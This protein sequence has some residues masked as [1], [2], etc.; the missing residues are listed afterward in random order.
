MGAPLRSW[1]LR[2][3]NSLA[4]WHSTAAQQQPALL[5]NTSRAG[6]LAT[7]HPFL[8]PPLRNAAGT[9]PRTCRPPPASAG[10]TRQA[11]SPPLP[12]PRPAPPFFARTAATTT[13]EL[14]PAPPPPQPYL[15]RARRET[16]GSGSRRVVRCGVVLPTHDV[17]AGRELRQVGLGTGEAR[18]LELRLGGRRRKLLRRRRAVRTDLAGGGG[19]GCGEAVK[20]SCRTRPAPP[21]RAAAPPPSNTA[22]R[23]AGTAA[24]PTPHPPPHAPG[25]PPRPSRRW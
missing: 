3:G 8:P 9:R 22:R 1:P 2:S 21:C 12:L 6:R 13:S 24:P 23:T 11:S 4:G 14:T 20:R 17:I 7:E 16:R 19:G 18:R 25:G 5:S 15:D 10:S